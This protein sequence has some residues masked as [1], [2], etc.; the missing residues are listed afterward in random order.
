MKKTAVRDWIFIQTRFDNYQYEHSTIF[1]YIRTC[2]ERIWKCK[3]TYLKMSIIWDFISYSTYMVIRILV[4]A[5]IV[6]E[7]WKQL[8]SENFVVRI[9]ESSTHLRS[10]G[11]WFIL[12]RNFFLPT[13]PPLGDLLARVNQSVVYVWYELSKYRWGKLIILDRI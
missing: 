13:L 4:Y 6:R 12:D 8:T 1:S 7:K 11:V 5:C 9:G 10:Q 2:W 3:C